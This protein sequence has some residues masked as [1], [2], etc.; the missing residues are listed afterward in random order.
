MGLKGCRKM[1]VVYYTLALRGRFIITA[2]YHI[3]HAFAAAKIKMQITIPRLI[4]D[5]LSG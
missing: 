5:T 3:G 1:D 2:R 4:I